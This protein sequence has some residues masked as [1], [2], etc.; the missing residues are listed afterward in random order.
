MAY[1]RQSLPKPLRHKKAKGQDTLLCGLPSNH[2]YGHP[3]PGLLEKALEV[4]ALCVM[5]VSAM[6]ETNQTSGSF[7]LLIL[8][9]TF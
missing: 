9:G 6:R 1:L 3:K 8:I 5:P 4:L 7:R 2:V